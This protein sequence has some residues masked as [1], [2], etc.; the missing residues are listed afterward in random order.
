MLQRV[1]ESTIASAMRASNVR[2][3][4]LAEPPVRPYKPSVP[5]NSVLGLIPT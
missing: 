1:K 4:D 3:V 2:I 5:I